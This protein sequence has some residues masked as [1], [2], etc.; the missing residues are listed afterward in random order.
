MQLAPRQRAKLS[1]L[2]IVQRQRAEAHTREIANLVPYLGKHA[3]HLAVAPFPQREL[4]YAALACALYDGDKRAPG[5]EAALVRI[6]EPD[7]SLQ[8][9]ERVAVHVAIDDRPIGF[10]HAIARV[11]K[12]VRQLAIICEQKK[13][14]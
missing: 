9:G 3:S 11:R 13:A 2:Q 7:A 5:L 4:Q 8:L 14:G 12:A 6:G 1:R 10:P